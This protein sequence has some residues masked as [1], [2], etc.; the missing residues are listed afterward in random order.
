M[1][2][3]VN[4]D[5]CLTICDFSAL[6]KDFNCLGY[7]LGV[8][9]AFTV[10]DGLA[11]VSLKPNFVHCDCLVAIFNSFLESLEIDVNLGTYSVDVSE[12]RG[13]RLTIRVVDFVLFLADRFS[14]IL[15]S[16]LQIF[17]LVCLVTEILRRDKSDWGL[18]LDCRGR[19]A[20]H[21]PFSYPSLFIFNL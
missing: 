7:C 14:V 12:R 2:N 11:D 3:D 1:L 4:V 8:L 20:W 17:F 10:G 21:L 6:L 5:L 19:S 15:Q 9:K 16:K 13:G 18:L